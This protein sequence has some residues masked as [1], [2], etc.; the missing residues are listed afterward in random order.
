LKQITLLNS[1]GISVLFLVIA[2]LMM[3]TMGYVFSY[4]I[5]TKQKTISFAIHS[6]QAFYLSQSGVEYAVRFATDQ[7]WTTSASLLGLNAPG[8]NQ[9]NLGRG[10]FTISYNNL[11]DQLTSIGQVLNMSERRIIISN[12]TTF[13]STGLILVA[14]VP[15]WTNP[16]TVARFYIQNVGSAAVTLTSF[17]ASWR[18]PPVRTLT[19]ILMDGVQKFG[20]AYSS[21]GGVSNFTPVG[22]TQ[23]VNASQT[24]MVNV[25]WNQNIN[26]NSAV[27]ISFYD[28]T[29]KQYIFNLDPEGDG[30]P[31]C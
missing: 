1:K 31:G 26:P 22:T 17:S 6:N 25:Q 4:L 23:T 28:S 12:F 16:R 11:T 30:L 29:G 18:E 27:V 7:G 10:S 14:P 20:G 3:V 19:S 21:G 2:M 9:R 5:P 15:C 13:I 24:I 8:V